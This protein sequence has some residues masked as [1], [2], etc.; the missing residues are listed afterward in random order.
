[1][2]IWRLVRVLATIRVNEGIYTAQDAAHYH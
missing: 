2:K 1:M